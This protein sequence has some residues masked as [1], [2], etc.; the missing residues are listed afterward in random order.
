ML[1]IVNGPESMDNFTFHEDEHGNVLPFYDGGFFTGTIIDVH[2]ELTYEDSTLIGVLR[3]D[4]R[5][6]H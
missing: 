4:E 1:I 2:G 6:L 5:V 3:Y